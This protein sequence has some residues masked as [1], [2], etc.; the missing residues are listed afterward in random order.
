MV[1]FTVQTAERL[2]LDYDITLVDD[3]SGEHTG[4]LLEEIVR[5]YPNVR[6]VRHEKNRG[7]GGALRSGFAAATR[8][9]IFYTDGDAQYDV[10]ELDV[11]L[12]EAGPEI[13]VVQGYKITRNDPMY[14]RIIGRI[15]HYIVKFAFGLRLRDVDCDFRLIRRSALDKVTLVSN[16]GVIC[17]EMMAKIQRQGFRV[18]EVPVHHFQRAHGKSQF[19]QLRR[20]L[21]VARQLTALWV[22]LV[23]L[24]R[25]V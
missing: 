9:W 24:R 12:R 15:Y 16:S 14:R 3:G 7:Y 21:R 19:F 17:C 18:K 8:E 6:V 10:R 2:G 1:M 23:L 5:R 13:D 20:I 22:R 25:E 4:E 11:L